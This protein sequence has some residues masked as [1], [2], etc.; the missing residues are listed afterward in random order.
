MAGFVLWQ[1]KGTKVPL[2]TRES[3][4]MILRVWWLTSRSEHL[5]LKACERSSSDHV[6][7]RVEFLDADLLY[8]LFLPAR[9]RLLGC[10]VWRPA[11][12]NHTYT[13]YIL[14]KISLP[15]H[16]LITSQHYSVPYLVL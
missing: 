15:K 5:H 1:W 11:T 9:L 10:Q 4:T 14:F 12:A 13:K 16:P 8:S 2:V 7:Q 3:R 6:R